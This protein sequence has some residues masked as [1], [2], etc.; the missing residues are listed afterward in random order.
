MRWKHVRIAS[1]AGVIPPVAVSSEE[2]EQRL[3][4]LYERLRLPAGRLEL[5]TGIRERHFWPEAVLPSAVATAAAEKCLALSRLPRERI[6]LLAH[7]AVCRDRLEPATAAY[8]H[9]AL[10]LGEGTLFWD[11][12]N[13]CLGFLN[14]MTLAATLIE[15][16]QI[17]AALL[18][19]GEDGRPLLERTLQVLLTGDFDRQSVKPY[20][21]NLTI[22][23]GAVAMVLAH[24]DATDSQRRLTG[25][26]A[27]TDTKANALCQGGQAMDGLGYDMLTDS[28]ALLEAGIALARRTWEGFQL[29]TG[30]PVEAIDHTI[31]HQV[32]RAHQRRLLEALR[33]D[34]AKDFVTYP[35]LG[36]TGS[37]A[38]PLTLVQAEAE[39]RFT[40]G[41]KVALLGIGSGL[42]CLMAGIEYL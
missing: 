19:S 28:E 22:G 12:S 25:A 40:S 26:W 37:A 27:L 31:C 24:E 16:G 33:L 10:G 1:L 7:C 15:A 20:F 4:P 18:V 42:S 13:A 9:Q 30:W 17:E 3:A 36:N 34:P 29:Q 21:A 35:Y 41:D 5:M 8:V 11:I 32:G 14:A 2:I 39:G 23:A 6:G 38:C